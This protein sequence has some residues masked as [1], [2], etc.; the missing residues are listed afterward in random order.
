MNGK[1]ALFF[2][3]FLKSSGH[4][5]EIV[6][7]VCN[8]ILEVVE[9]VLD[10]IGKNLVLLETFSISIDRFIE[11]LSDH[12]SAGCFDLSLKLLLLSKVCRHLS[13]VVGSPLLACLDKND[14]VRH[15]DELDLLNGVHVEAIRELFELWPWL[16]HS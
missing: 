5:P 15:M 16:I 14:C 13:L 4:D 1:A 11:V 2:D 3:E 10:I 9:N 8:I 6:V 7:V 12:K